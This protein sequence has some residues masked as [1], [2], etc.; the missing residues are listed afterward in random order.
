MASLRENDGIQP[1]HIPWLGSLVVDPAYR[2]QKVG[3]KLIAVVKN[4]ASLF[5][6]KKLYLLAFDPTIHIWYEKLGW[7][8]IGNDQLFNYPVSVMDIGI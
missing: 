5:G 7:K 4:Q 8:L 1:H 2:S 3:E 6:Y